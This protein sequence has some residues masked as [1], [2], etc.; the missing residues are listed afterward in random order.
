[1]VFGD[2]WLE[3]G[4][5]L[6]FLTGAPG[7]GKTVLLGLVGSMLLMAGASETV[8]Q[9]SKEYVEI[10]GSFIPRYREALD[11]ERGYVRVEQAYSGGRCVMELVGS[12][13]YP[14][15]VSCTSR[16]AAAVLM[17]YRVAQLRML[18]SKVPGECPHTLEGHLCSLVKEVAASMAR[19]GDPWQ[20]R[21]ARRFNEIAGRLLEESVHEPISFETMTTHRGTPLYRESYTILNLVTIALGLAYTSTHTPSTLIVDTPEHGLTL[22]Q[23]PLL[24]EAIAETVA[25]YEDTQVLI[26][27]HNSL[28]PALVASKIAAVKPEL[29]LEKTVEVY[30]LVLDRKAHKATINKL[31]LNRIPDYTAEGYRRVLKTIEQLKE[32]TR[33]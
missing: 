3:T 7:S 26:A 33:A 32:K 12:I 16:P 21:L 2:V 20:S 13:G 14:R 27:T 8:R 24:A 1:M 9:P 25:Q 29:D 31:P 19:Y 22:H 6:V 15:L 28:I 23:L 18:A 4:A 5:R 10:L 11:R 30:E 17:E